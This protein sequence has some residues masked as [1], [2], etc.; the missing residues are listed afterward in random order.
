[1]APEQAAGKNKEVGA[2]ADVYALGAVLYECLVGRPPF[3]AA[4]PL[5]TL[6]QV[7]GEEPVPPRQLQPK[8]PADLETI[9]LKCLEKEQS[10]R[11]ATA[12][13]LAEDL[14]RFQAGEAIAARPV[15][16]AERA[17]KWVRRNPVVAGLAAAVGAALVLGAGVAA[18]FGVKAESR[19]STPAVPASASGPGPPAGRPGATSPGPEHQ[20]RPDAPP[21]PADRPAR[22]A[23]GR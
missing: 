5:D 12:A 20:W 19:S 18:V 6:L 17:W 23:A 15:T 22:T 10:K 21:E 7:L 11:Y 13:A 1:M 2:P 8:T 14:R 3:K 16:A 9:C 4:T